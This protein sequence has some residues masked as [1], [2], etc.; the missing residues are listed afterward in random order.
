M[1][2]FVT[3]T[4]PKEQ[5]EIVG[6]DAESLDCAQKEQPSSF[7]SKWKWQISALFPIIVVLIGGFVYL[8]LRPE[9]IAVLGTN[10]EE[11][12]PSVIKVAE[13]PSMA[14][15]SA[16]L[17]ETTESL[18]TETTTTFYYI[19][20]VDIDLENLDNVEN[21]DNL[22]LILT[23]SSEPTADDLADSMSIVIENVTS[24]E[25]PYKLEDVRVVD[26][27]NGAIVVEDGREVAVASFVSVSDFSSVDLPPVLT[28]SLSGD[29]GISGTVRIDYVNEFVKGELQPIPRLLL[30][31]PAINGAPGPYLYLSKRPLS[32][33]RNRNL[34][35]DDIYIPIDESGG[36]FSVKGRF[37]QI[38]D[39]LSLQ[40]LNEYANGS[41]VV[42]CRPFEAWIGGGS[43]SAET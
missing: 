27:I 15:G 18:I 5:N 11:S 33:S 7:W 29:Y 36:S 23:A 35:N 1:H 30:D 34:N 6:M 40:D 32:E 22:D 24:V 20:F 2:A 17:L 12:F 9:N 31:I 26:N 21:P 25:F 39:E 4:I 37:D 16:I 10:Q 38:L 14:E 13:V 41:W 19:R 43:I 42:W 3:M 28:S 8:S